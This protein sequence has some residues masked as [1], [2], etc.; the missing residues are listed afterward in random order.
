MN[1]TQQN[2]RTRVSCNQCAQKIP[3][4]TELNNHKQINHDQNKLICDQCAQKFSSEIELNNHK[5]IKHNIIS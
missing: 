2:Y 1:K 5:Q 3:S 4:E